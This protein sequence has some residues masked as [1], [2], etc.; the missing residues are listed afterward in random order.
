LQACIG[1]GLEVFLV[2]K[3]SEIAGGLKD[4]RVP[5]W[6]EGCRK[7][8]GPERT[9]GYVLGERGKIRQNVLMSEWHGVDGRRIAFLIEGCFAIFFVVDCFVDIYGFDNQ[10]GGQRKGQRG[11]DMREPTG[12][13]T[14]GLPFVSGNRARQCLDWEVRNASTWGKGREEDGVGQGFWAGIAALCHARPEDW[15]GK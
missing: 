12:A 1:G 15:N 10:N 2:N 9:R 4:K 11:N 3:S 6:G 5:S 14:P 7:S 8:W 13:I